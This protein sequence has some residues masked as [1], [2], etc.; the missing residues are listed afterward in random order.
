MLGRNRELAAALFAWAVL[1]GGICL[2]TYLFAGGFAAVWA[3]AAGVAALVP[4]AV[5]TWQRYRALARLSER[6]DGLLHGER[7]LGFDGMREGELAIL[8]N[9]LDKLVQRLT[10]TAEQLGRERTLLADSLADISHQLRTPLTSLSLTTELIRKR[11]AEHP[12][13]IPAADASAIAVRLRT[14]ERL[15]EHIGW[16]VATLL[17][18][19]RIDAGVV[20]LACQPVDAGC[21][22]RKAADELAIAFDL[23]DVEPVFDIQPQ[24]GFT[25]D[26]D[27]TVEALANVLKNC[28]EHTPAGGQVHV[29]VSEDALACRIR[30]EDTGPGIA[31]ADLAHIFERFYRGRDAAAEVNPAGVGIGL[32]LAKSLVTAQGGSIR[33]DNARDAAG[34]VTGARFDIAFFKTVV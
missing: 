13:G 22:V 25:G 1:T 8:T 32:A 31:E 24:A 23:A 29:T 6:I 28:L 10:R 15:Q 2:L 11:V 19:A 21:A 33:A 34:A 5:V 30:I 4:W 18:L 14:A 26:A 7:P 27:W 16:L 20:Q 3:L 9:E 17:K 12:K